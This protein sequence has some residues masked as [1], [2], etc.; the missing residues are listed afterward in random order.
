MSG[1]GP[2]VRIDAP[3][4]IREPLED[5]FRDLTGPP[6]ATI[7]FRR[8]GLRA[9]RSGTDEQSHVG[10]LGTGLHECLIALNRAAAARFA[11][12][13]TAVH[14]GCVA[15]D[16]RAVALVGVSGSGKT[17][18]TAA[19]VLAGWAYLADE[20]CAVDAATLEVQPYP[21]PLGL[22]PESLDLLAVDPPIGPAELFTEVAPTRG[23]RLGALADPTPLAAVV[24]VERLDAE[25]PREV[26]VDPLSPAETLV[27]LCHHSLRTPGDERALFRRLETVARAV[28]GSVLRYREATDAAAALH[29]VFGR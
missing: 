24:F 14:A 22:R 6:L 5:A 13:H 8:S 12:D 23:S 28:P 20:V 17:T 10:D 26:L 27:Q 25:S 7:T 3:R 15:R 4:R 11:R 21:R 29:Q 19:A 16:G 2:A 9:W 1:A 18:L